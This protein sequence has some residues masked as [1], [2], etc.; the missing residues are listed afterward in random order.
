MIQKRNASPILG[1]ALAGTRCI[2]RL[3]PPQSRVWHSR[4]HDWLVAVGEVRYSHFGVNSITLGGA[5][6]RTEMSCSAAT[7]CIEGMDIR[8]RIGQSGGR[9]RRR[10]G[11]RR[12]VADHIR[13]HCTGR[14]FGRTLVSSQRIEMD[15]HPDN[16]PAR[17]RVTLLRRPPGA[18]SLAS[19]GEGRNVKATGPTRANSTSSICS[20]SISERA[21]GVALSQQL[22]DAC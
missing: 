4:G 19:P 5:V 20:K 14:V 7:P 16:G 2:W 6:R 13:R 9:R 22:L 8:I 18:R 3:R 1:K 15:T 11:P 12:F 21:W 10:K 17:R